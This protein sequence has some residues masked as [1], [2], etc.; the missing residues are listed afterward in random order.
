MQGPI[1]EFIIFFQKY[2]GT[3]MDHCATSNP[4][5]GVHPIFLQKYFDTL[6]DHCEASNLQGS[7]YLSSK[8]FRTLMDQCA[9][10]NPC[11]SANFPPFRADITRQKTAFDKFYS[12]QNHTLH[13]A[14]KA[15]EA[16]LVVATLHRAALC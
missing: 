5:P 16:T 4:R 15:N 7:Y 6:M 3:R 13:S 12:L 9:S 14:R 8:Y 1:H 10:S 2:I 11:F